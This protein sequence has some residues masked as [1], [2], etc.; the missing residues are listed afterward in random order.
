MISEV[1][2]IIKALEKY[3]QLLCKNDYIGVRTLKLNLISSIN[4]RFEEHFVKKDQLLATTSD[5][6]LKAHGFPDNSSQKKAMDLVR[7][8]I[9]NIMEER[10]LAAS[11]HK[12]DSKHAASDREEIPKK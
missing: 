5:P 12:A 1:L 7:H 8:G 2:P 9:K 4:K 6:R 11:H 3:I 10:A